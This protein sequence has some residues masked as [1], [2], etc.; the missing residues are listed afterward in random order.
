[1]APS[2][3]RRSL[4]FKIRKRSGGKNESHQAI[5]AAYKETCVVGREGCG[6]QPPSAALSSSLSLGHMNLGMEWRHFQQSAQV[7]FGAVG[8]CMHAWW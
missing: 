4:D 3:S 5:C 7:V 6:G 8:S 2:G 1:M